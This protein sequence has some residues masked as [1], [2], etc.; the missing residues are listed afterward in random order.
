MEP[1]PQPCKLTRIETPFVPTE[2][3][4]HRGQV[5]TTV[6]RPTPSERS[7]TLPTGERWDPK[8]EQ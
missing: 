7:V 8:A 6:E 2:A 4:Q 3:I 5:H 1:K